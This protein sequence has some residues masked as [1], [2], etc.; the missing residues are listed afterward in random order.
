[1]P[2]RRWSGAFRQTDSQN[3]FPFEPLAAFLF[4]LSLCSVISA[5]DLTRELLH[6]PSGRTVE[7]V[8]RSLSPGEP[9]FFLLRTSGGIG[10]V[11]VRF[12]NETSILTAAGG[13]DVAVGFHGID[14]GIQPGTY[15]LSVRIEDEDSTFE[16]IQIDV[17]VEEKDFPVSKLRMKQEYVSPPR[18]LDERLRRESEIMGWIYEKITPVWMGDGNFVLPHPADAWPNFGQKRLVNERVQSLHS[19]VDLR[20]PWGDPVRSV[21]TG[22]VV[23]ASHYYMPGKTVII[24]HGLGVFSFYCHL[25]D[26]L[27]KRGSRIRKGEIIGRCG[28]TGRST[29]PHLHWSMRILDSRVDPHAMLLLPLDGIGSAWPS[30]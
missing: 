14:L 2:K 10:R 8:Y 21:N 17:V 28:N 27:V 1:M 18:E 19:G 26:I 15:P 29:G 7:L 9:L 13:G 6:A 30:K 25:S 5:E 23:F 12:L 24:D 3:S 22:I 11:T 4:F 20:V 16:E